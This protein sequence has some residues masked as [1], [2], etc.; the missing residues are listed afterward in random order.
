[1]QVC[2]VIL[3][4]LYILP[5]WFFF[6]GLCFRWWAQ[7]SLG[8]ELLS[9]E[10]TMSL[11]NRINRI[12]CY[13]ECYHDTTGDDGMKFMHHHRMA[14]SYKISLMWNVW[15]VLKPNKGQFDHDTIKFKALGRQYLKF[16]LLGFTYPE[17]I[18][19]SHSYYSILENPN[20]PPFASISD[21][22]ADLCQRC[23]SAFVYFS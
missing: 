3:H 7:T 21:W 8:D 18:P 4:F 9:C 10:W 5:W 14:P 17:S 23:T 20:V 15:K 6:V 12:E 11:F 22:L 16:I 1:M 13:I 2:T 19:F